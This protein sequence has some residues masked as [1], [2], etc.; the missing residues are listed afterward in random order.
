MAGFP[1]A[2]GSL[3][4]TELHLSNKRSDRSA[5]I[6]DLLDQMHKMVRRGPC[7]KIKKLFE[8]ASYLAGPVSG[9]F[10]LGF[11]YKTGRKEVVPRLLTEQLVGHRLSFVTDIIQ[12]AEMGVQRFCAPQLK[13]NFSYVEKK[14]TFRRREVARRKCDE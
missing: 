14:K 5:E 12:N 8:S 10:L 13:I 7:L 4:M 11:M 9:N 1:T 3:K 6:L 2:F